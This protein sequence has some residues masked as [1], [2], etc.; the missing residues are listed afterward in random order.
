MVRS[1]GRGRALIFLE[2]VSPISMVRSQGVR[3]ALTDRSKRM[4]GVRVAFDLSRPPAG[5]PPSLRQRQR[6]ANGAFGKPQSP[7]QRI[8]N[9]RT[10]RE[11]NTRRFPSRFRIAPTHCSL[12]IGFKTRVSITSGFSLDAQFDPSTARDQ[13]LENAWNDWLIDRCAELL[14]DV[15]TGFAHP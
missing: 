1:L 9:P 15:A 8:S 5:D 3:H 4:P 2:S 11:A 13:L 14:A 6:P 7:F 12:Y 10:R